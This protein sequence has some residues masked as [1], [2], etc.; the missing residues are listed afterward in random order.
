MIE[1]VAVPG[2]DGDKRSAPL[3]AVQRGAPS[4]GSASSTIRPS[5][6]LARDRRLRRRHE[7]PRV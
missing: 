3:T 7:P 2:H 1:V 4:S 6:P 5:G